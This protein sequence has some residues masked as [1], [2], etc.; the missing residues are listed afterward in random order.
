[1][2][3]SLTQL[4][5]SSRFRA[6]QINLRSAGSSHLSCCS[7]SIALSG[8]M[9]TFPCRVSGLRA[10]S[11][12]RRQHHAPIGQVSAR[13]VTRQGDGSFLVGRVRAP[14]S[15]TRL[16]DYSWLPAMTTSGS[17]AMVSSVV[18][19]RGN[20]ALTSGAPS[21]PETLR[22]PSG[23]RDCVNPIAFGGVFWLLVVAARCSGLHP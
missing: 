17:A 15:L 4:R 3:K 16:H 13:F 12:V 10:A 19:A 2:W 20:T 5:R 22:Y 21:V 8:Q 11:R 23:S 6:S 9:C 1:M 7:T 18:P 14:G